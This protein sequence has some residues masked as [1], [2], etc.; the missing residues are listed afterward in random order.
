M[1]DY[2][3]V[4]TLFP[5]LDLDI[6]TKDGRLSCY[7]TWFHHNVRCDQYFN[8]TCNG[9]CCSGGNKYKKRLFILNT[10]SSTW[11]ALK[12]IFLG[13]KAMDEDSNWQLKK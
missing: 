2:D 1:A 13:E 3:V 5:L 4:A 9:C 10:T 8:H 11:Q 12:E 7:D 6:T